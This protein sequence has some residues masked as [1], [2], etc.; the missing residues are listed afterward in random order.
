MY[1]I[2]RPLTFA[3]SQIAK[4]QSAYQD[5][6]N[7]K[8]LDPK[9][10]AKAA[11]K[12]R[13]PGT[14]L[15]PA[16]IQSL[17]NGSTS[18]WGAM[19]YYRAYL[20]GEQI[21]ILSPSILHTREQQFSHLCYFMICMNNAKISEKVETRYETLASI[22]DLRIPGTSKLGIELIPEKINV[23]TRNGSVTSRSGIIDDK[24]PFTFFLA[25]SIERT[26]GSPVNLGFGLIIDHDKDII[27]LNLKHGRSATYQH[28]SLH[29]N[30]TEAIATQAHATSADKAWIWPAIGSRNKKRDN[31]NNNMYTDFMPKLIM[32]DYNRNKLIQIL[33]ELPKAV[34]PKHPN[35]N[36]KLWWAVVD[37]DYSTIEACIAEGADVN[38]QEPTHNHTPLHAASYQRDMR[39]IEMLLATRK[40]NLS[41]FEKDGCLPNAGLTYKERPIFLSLVKKYSPKDSYLYDSTFSQPRSWL[42]RLSL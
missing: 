30:K 13:W 35:L 39:T 25:Q 29:L 26:K 10:I 42:S 6:N 11:N 1:E 17:L 20:Y 4:I 2:M 27:L 24:R 19:K 37:Q 16:D 28:I 14:R 3:G 32:D 41:L 34:R 23:A 36:E 8:S 18:R 15:L 21:G 38:F 31:T 7:R 5:L 9:E 22:Y 40:C 33:E 12:I